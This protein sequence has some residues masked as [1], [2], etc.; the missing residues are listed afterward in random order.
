MRRLLRRRGLIGSGY[1]AVGKGVRPV[2]LYWGGLEAFGVGIH[3]I[4]YFPS[5]RLRAGPLVM[6]LGALG[7]G[8]TK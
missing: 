7:V 1:L 5:A 8:S 3:W 2:L 6:A 4:A